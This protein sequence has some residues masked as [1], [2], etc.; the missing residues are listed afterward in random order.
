MDAE[1]RLAY[2]QR[3]LRGDALKKYRQVLITCRK[4]ANE[5]VG[6]EWTLRN[7]TR[8]S[9]EDFWTW[10]KTDIKGYDGHYYLARDKCVDLERYLWFEFGKCMWRKHRSFYQDHMKYVCND[11]VKPFKVKILRYVARLRGM[12]D[13]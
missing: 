6:D 11:I 13:L 12:H 9:A 5:I 4:L 7:L 8:L 10:K 3:V 2:K 1:N